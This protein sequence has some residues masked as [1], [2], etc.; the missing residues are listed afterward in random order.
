MSNVTSV[1]AAKSNKPKKTAVKVLAYVFLIAL[2]LIILIPF[3]AIFAGTFLSTRKNSC[4]QLLR[5]IRFGETEPDTSRVPLFCKL[6]FCRIFPT[7]FVKPG[8]AFRFPFWEISIFREKH[9][10]FGG[11]GQHREKRKS[12]AKIIATSFY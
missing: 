6:R 12:T 7:A 9:C 3:W 1:S 10:L 8:A 2:A 4:R 5:C 11:S